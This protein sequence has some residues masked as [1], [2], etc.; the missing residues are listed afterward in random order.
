[1][2]TLLARR[3][4]RFMA[5]RRL[6]GES[7]AHRPDTKVLDRALKRLI[8][9]RYIRRLGSDHLSPYDITG[10][11]RRLLVRIRAIIDFDR[12][13]RRKLGDNGTGDDEQRET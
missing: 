10:R 1:M 6:L 9:Q 7:A 13:Q 12:E 2:L 5:I 3:P 8:R 11:G 4:L